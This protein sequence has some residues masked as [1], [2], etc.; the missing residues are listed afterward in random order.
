MSAVFDIL[1]KNIDR[2][3]RRYYLN[4]L[5][6]G[7]IFFG[8]GLLI[9]FLLLVSIEYFGYLGTN[10]R[11]VLFYFFLLYNAAIFVYYVLLPLFGMI[12]IGRK[13]TPEEAARII[14][15][16]YKTE[17]NDKITN[18]LQLK[19][20]LD[21]KPENATLILAGI[22]QKASGINLIPFKNAIPIKG[23]LRFL[24]YVLVPLMFAALFYAISPAF[25]IEPAARIVQYETFFERPTPFSFVMISDNT[26]FRH[27]DKEIIVEATGPVMPTEARLLIN[28]TAYRM[29]DAGSNSFSYRIRN[30][31]EDI[32]F[33]IESGGFRFGPF[34]I[35]VYE[36]PSINHFQVKVRYPGYTGFADDL[37][38]NLGDLS[39]IQESE[40]EFTFFTNPYNEIL[41]R[42]QNN[43]L[44]PEKE[45]EGVFSFTVRASE[46]F[47]YKVYAHHESL[48]PGD[49]LNYFINVIPDAHPR[50][51]VEEHRDDILLAHLFYRGTIEDDFGFSALKFRYRALNQRQISRGEEVPFMAETVDIDHN[52]K[53]QTFYYH[54]DLNSIYARPGETIEAYFEVFD[55]DPINGPKSARSRMF[56]YYIPTEEEILADRRRTEERIDEGLS[57]GIGEAQ[58]ARDQID[59][60]RRQ[61]L[62]T[63]RMGWEQRE[64]LQELLRKKDEME[65]MVQQLADEKQQ[66]ETKSEQFMD[67][68]EALREKQEEL[69]RLFDEVLSD[70]LKELFEKIREELDNLSRDAVYEMLDQME[71]EFRDLELQMDRTLEMFRQFAMER[72]LQESIDR[73]D[74]LA[75]E[76]E[77]LG[78]T[79]GEGGQEEDAERQQEDIA[80]KFDHISEMLEEFRE[81]N[82]KLQRPKPIEDTSAEENAIR[83]QMQQALEQLMMNNMDEASSLQKDAGGKMKELSE[84]LSNMQQSLF[85]QQLAE[86]ARAIRMM[87]ENLLRSSFS[88]EDLMLETRQANVNDPRFL[89][90]LRE[91]RKIQSDLQM[92][93]D[94]LIA[95]SKRQIAIQSFVNSEIAEINMQMRYGIEHMINRR[96]HQAASRQQLIMTHINNL[97]LMLNE[98]LQ[99]IQQQM[100]MGEGM[101][102]PSQSGE[103]GMSFQ[104]LRQ[105]QEQLNEML[106]QL[107]QGEQPM[108]GETGQGQ[109]SMSEQMARMAAEQ[110]A[111][112]NKLR[113]LSDEMRNQGMDGGRELDQLQRD[114]ER[115]ELDML[116]KQITRQ[117]IRRQEQILVRLLEHERAEL[118]REQEER[119]EGTTAKNY[120]IS[121]PEDFFE[122]NRIR[123]REVEM[124]RS[125]PP[126]LRPFYRSLVE[127]YFLHVE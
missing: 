104:D 57:E 100:A 34:R 10:I 64:M 110:E 98:S 75:E 85:Q 56:T 124:L 38:T 30:L 39:V 83:Q 88:Q 70:E 69:Q 3:I 105:M 93:E 37:Y 73:L 119:R 95:L 125:L 29:Q 65:Q 97:A 99:D 46:S 21:E 94:S 8:A 11:F 26:A 2:F 71:F 53:N 90:L 117:T 12:R 17:L 43:T 67:K 28:R 18:V 22:E 20:Y 61:L 31:Q 121:N 58:Q 109:M 122:Y 24:P 114:M 72:L 84:Q 5:I 120:E 16:H 91:Q 27:E 87:L 115:S 49:S 47:S 113:Q 48:G 13:V 52:L 82:N 96:R 32:E 78:N 80:E 1:L 101:G 51:A 76:Q 7:S 23:N 63:D 50:I 36:K 45:R 74:K 103:G 102:D 33:F 107:Q 66:S 118:Q 92:I 108:P 127:T 59:E 9:L 25:L 68:P 126:G 55:N 44:V 112:R 79:T 42:K 81:L 14:G 86:D 54:F 106:N 40:M 41:F 19:R 4:Q 89:E 60:L 15:K 77:E 35:N 6:K 62:D 111:I 123:E 116:R